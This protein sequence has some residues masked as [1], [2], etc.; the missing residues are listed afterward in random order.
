MKLRTRPLLLGLAL[1]F[2]GCKNSDIEK[3]LGDYSGYVIFEVNKN[4]SQELIKAHLDKG[5][6]GFS[7]KVQ[8]A[9]SPKTWSFGFSITSQNLVLTSDQLQKP[10]LLK[11]I[12]HNC[13]DSNQD[14]PSAR[15]CYDDQSLELNLKMVD[16][17]AQDFILESV[18]SV[19]A[20]PVEEPKAYTQDELITRA[21]DQSFST[22][23]SFQNVVLARQNA[24][25]ATANL[26]PHISAN[27]LIALATPTVLTA[28]LKVVG[29][30]SPFLLPGR[31]IKARQDEDYYDAQ[32][33]SWLLMRADAGQ[34]AEGL[35]Y[36]DLSIHDSQIR[37]HVNR[38]DIV[39]DR[40]LIRDREKSGLVPIGTSDAVTAVI[41]DIDQS[42]RA[43]QTLD[44]ITLGALSE[45]VGFFSSGAVSKV[46]A[47]SGDVTV[48]HPQ[49]P[50]MDDVKT[51]VL[52]HSYEIAQMTSLLAA[53]KLDKAGRMFN[54]LDPNG[55][56]SGGLGFGFP[57][58]V[59]I[60]DTEVKELEA[61]KSEVEALLDKRVN[62]VLESMQDAVDEYGL[63]SDDQLVEDRRV[64]VIMNELSL[65]LPFNTLELVAALQGRIKD[66]LLLIGAGYAYASSWS[67]LNRLLYAG[68]YVELAKGRLLSPDFDA[69][70]K[71]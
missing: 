27:S 60:A 48:L 66:D 13:Y 16:G 50:T 18:Q 55:D 17:S 4:Q 22:Q 23:V 3:H 20:P 49:V 69:A 36:A 71:K 70:M 42:L 32:L 56:V 21:I 8:S 51:T 11:A 28:L 57:T 63:A 67:R 59:K 15:V 9:Q 65:G 58:Y 7:A 68:P 33:Y 6:G 64:A 5:N 34:I 62:E 30:L 44:Q 35:S 37:L 45:S 31:W 54:W 61:Q 24:E 41:D 53:A 2:V 52:A 39:A 26:L 14:P 43:S 29:D 10:L 19:V 38:Q 40:D 46:L 47:R 25:V 1:A 12:G